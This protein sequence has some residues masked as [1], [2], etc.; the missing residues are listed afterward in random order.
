MALPDWKKVLLVDLGFL[1]DTVHSI[2]AIRALALSGIQMDV[3]TTAVGAELLSLVPEVHQTWTVPL[4]KPSPP[5]WKNLGTLVKIRRQK[6]DAAITFSGADRNL[7][8]TAGSGATERIATLHRTRWWL[9]LLPLTRELPPPNRNQPMYQQKLA[10]LQ[11][12][13]WAGDH[14]GWS[15]RLP[16][17]LKK[18]P[19]SSRGRPKVYLSIS[20]FGSPLKEWP[21]G[22]WAEMMR[23]VWRTRADVHF[24]IGYAPNERERLRAQE[25]LQLAKNPPGVSV[26]DAP[27]GL[28]ELTSLLKESDL[29]AGLDSGVLHLAAA[30]GLSTVSV[31]RDYRG[32]DEW[33]IPGQNHRV[34]LG[35]CLCDQHGRNRCGV[36]SQCLSS[37]EPERTAAAVL[38]LLPAHGQDI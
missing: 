26:L 16:D 34:L 17:V 20:A 24:T 19:P 2:P 6:Y 33:M 9:P 1:G 11:S 3:M 8:C 21:L 23:T 25:L 30:L 22:H 32:K 29:F 10:T 37:I 5:P 12:L 13:G 31:F 14:P 36:V 28:A 27:L 7:F 38:A 4:R 35:P 18:T 15:W